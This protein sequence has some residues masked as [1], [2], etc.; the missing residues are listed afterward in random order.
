MKRKFEYTRKLNPCFYLIVGGLALANPGIAQTPAEAVTGIGTK[1][2]EPAE[3]PTPAAKQEPIPAAKSKTPMMDALILQLLKGEAI[4]DE[5]AKQ[6]VE[7]EFGMIFRNEIMDPIDPADSKQVRAAKYYT[8]FYLAAVKASMLDVTNH[9]GWP[10]S[11]DK[12]KKPETNRLILAELKS[13]VRAKPD[14]ANKAIINY[15]IIAPAWILDDHEAMATS[16]YELTIDWP[17]NSFIAR[18]AANLRARVQEQHP[19]K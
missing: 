9:G 14:A 10:S 5:K 4:D 3:K 17:G 16:D 19:K 2:G 12:L 1:S 11:Y 15:A 13:R 18:K 7:K 6:T 8:T